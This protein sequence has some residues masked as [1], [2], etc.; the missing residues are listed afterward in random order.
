MNVLPLTLLSYKNIP[1]RPCEC[2]CCF[3]QI[4]QL[5]RKPPANDYIK[6][7]LYV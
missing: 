5:Y 1:E 3:S 4:G 2:C 6:Y 7:E